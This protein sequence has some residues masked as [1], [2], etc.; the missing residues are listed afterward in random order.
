VSQFER[1]LATG[2]GGQLASD[3]EALLAGECDFRTLSHAELDIADAEAVERAILESRAEVLFNC[4][5]F[6]N[7][8]VC[9]REERRSFE[10]NV[11]AVKRM[12]ELCEK[13]GVRLV[14][15]STNY[16]F[17]G[18]AEAPYREDDT[19]APQSIYALSKL[20]G[21]YTA[22]TYAPRALVVRTG[23][24]YGQHGSASKGG[25]FVTRMLARAREQGE[26][27][28]VADQHL[29]PTP[30]ADL[31][32]AVVEAV[33]A[34]AD[35]VLHLTASGSCSWHEFTEA[36]VELAGV[37]VEVRPTETTRPPGGARRPRNGVL[38]RPRAD[39][40]GLT[41][42]PHWREGLE[43]YMQV[44]GLSAVSGVSS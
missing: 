5:A 39:A 16:V 22:L 2:G 40:L 9:E 18:S 11:T 43:S 37:E 14:H 42:L 44:A 10:V 32:A 15:L 20:G 17:G 33:W 19:P 26:L 24:L 35:G 29:S 38:A 28:V 21:E 23:G 1:A 3:L 13:H 31:A 4:A 6:H 7:V 8:E 36:I 30:T 34:G 12:A 25:N 41:P 27:A